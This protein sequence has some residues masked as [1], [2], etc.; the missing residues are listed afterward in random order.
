MHPIGLVCAAVLVAAVAGEPAS[1]RLIAHRGL[2]RHA[3]ENTLA[4]YG[5]CL[6]LRLGFELDVRRSKD[7]HLVIVHDADLKRT[8]DGKGRVADHTL[9]EL[10]KLDAGRWFDTSFTGERVPT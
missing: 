5:A 10:K 3:P 7:G 6:D 9:A 8:T 4:A 2:L 1:P